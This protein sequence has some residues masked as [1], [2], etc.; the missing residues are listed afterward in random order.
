MAVHAIDYY[1]VTRKIVAPLVWSGPSTTVII[2][3]FPDTKVSE[4]ATSCGSVKASKKGN[5]YDHEY[6][7]VETA[8]AR[9]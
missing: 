4:H 2:S 7:T 9:C 5:L 1:W 3:N 8:K 6:P